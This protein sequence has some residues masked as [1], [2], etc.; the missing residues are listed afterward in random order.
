MAIAGEERVGG[1][2]A[3]DVIEWANTA[4]NPLGTPEKA[5]KRYVPRLLPKPEAIVKE[6]R[7]Q[8]AEVVGRELAKKW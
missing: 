7:E 6:R 8:S 5:S 4:A 3:Q 2:S 1:G